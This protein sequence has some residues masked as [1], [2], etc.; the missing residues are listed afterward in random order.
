MDELNK[1]FKDHTDRRIREI[2]ERTKNIK[3]EKIKEKMRKI[4]EKQMK[5]RER[6][7]RKN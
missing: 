6:V 5:K 7:E 1:Y 2:H 3:A 4:S